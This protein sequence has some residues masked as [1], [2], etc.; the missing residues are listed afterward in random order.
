MKAHKKPYK[1]ANDVRDSKSFKYKHFIE[2]IIPASLSRND[3]R[4]SK[5]Q[6]ISG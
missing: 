6:D 1:A 4:Q 2:K 3:D 5:R